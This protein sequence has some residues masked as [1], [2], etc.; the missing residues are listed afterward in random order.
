MAADVWA[1]HLIVLLNNIYDTGELIASVVS[2]LVYGSGYNPN[3]IICCFVGSKGVIDK[4]ISTHEFQ[5]LHPFNK[6][7]ISCYS[8]FDFPVGWIVGFGM[9]D[10]LYNRGVM[11]IEVKDSE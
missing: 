7:S 8:I 4:K 1:D 10:K 5:L 11:Q 6:H 9:D 3:Q 2:D